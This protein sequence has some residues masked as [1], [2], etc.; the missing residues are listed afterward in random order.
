MWSATLG[1]LE[2]NPWPVRAD[3]VDH[4]D[5]LRIDLDPT[6]DAPSDHVRQRRLMA[7]DVLAEH[8]L[9][10]LPEDE[11]KRGHPRERPRRARAAPPRRTGARRWRSPARSSGACPASPPPP[12][13][14]RSATACS[15]TT[16]RTRA[17]ARWPAATRSDRCPTRGSRRRSS[18]NEVAGVEPPVHA[19]HRA[20]RL[21]AL[22]DPGAA[23]TNTLGPSTRCSSSRPRTPRAASTTHRGRRIPEGRRRTA[24]RGP[25]PREEGPRVAAMAP[26]RN[27]DQPRDD[28]ADAL[29]WTSAAGE[30]C[31]VDPRSP[32]RRQ[33]GSRWTREAAEERPRRGQED[34]LRPREHDRASREDPHRGPRHA[35]AGAR[36]PRGDRGRDLLPG[37]EGAPEDEGHRARGLRGAPRRRHGHGRARGRRRER[38]DLDRQVHGHEGEPRASHRGRGRR[39]VPAGS[40]RS[41][42]TASSRSSAT[43]CR[44]GRKS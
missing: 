10:R 25:L 17:I 8:G 31:L 12:G 26:D 36:G 5:E 22:G 23:S 15:S 14:R 11:G 16:T 3:D 33:R 13:G 20:E 19:A 2:C 44:L 7:R 1:C 43:A 32:R 9:D 29:V 34:A 4:P 27:R 35:E 40:S 28:P 21:R 41:S 39:D 6:P 18:G 24:A 38:R 30:P 42:P 37:A